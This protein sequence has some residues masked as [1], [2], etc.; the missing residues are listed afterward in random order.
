MQ[1]I[2]KLL[3]DSFFQS[4]KSHVTCIGF[5]Y[6]F[7][8][9]GSYREFVYSLNRQMPNANR[10]ILLINQQQLDT[11]LSYTFSIEYSELRAIM[12]LNIFQHIHLLHL[13]IGSINTS[14]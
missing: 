7:S 3:K 4:V 9:N 2:S 5:T 14:K 10:E 13:Y 6:A 11:L 1:K 8:I 12:T